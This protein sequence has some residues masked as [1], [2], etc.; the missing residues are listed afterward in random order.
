MQLNV[1]SPLVG[2]PFRERTTVRRQAPT[3]HTVL[4]QQIHLRIQIYSFLIKP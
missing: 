4:E 3:V 2:G 1:G